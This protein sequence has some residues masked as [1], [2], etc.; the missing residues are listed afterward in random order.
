M[1]ME[2]RQL[3]ILGGMGMAGPVVVGTFTVPSPDVGPAVVLPGPIPPEVPATLV[4]T[5][6]SLIVY[7]EWNLGVG[8]DA[9]RVQQC[10]VDVEPAP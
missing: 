7:T 10:L 9:T 5:V 2:L 8:S 6:A 4:G 3:M 1:K